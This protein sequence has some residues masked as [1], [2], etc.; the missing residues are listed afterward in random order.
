MHTLL[1]RISVILLPVLIGAGTLRA[2]EGAEGLPILT[3]T[4]TAA[5][6]AKDGQKV[7]VFGET[8]RSGKSGSGMNFV[9]FK[10]AEFYLVTFKSDLAA[11]K[12][13]EPSD[14]YNGKRLAVAGV[15]SIYK[16]KPQIKL[17]SPD[18]VR[19]LA[20]DEAWP[21]APE[22]SASVAP[23]APPVAKSD[24][25]AGAAKAVETP[26]KKPPVDP[27]QYFK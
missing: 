22:A 25:S 19:V 8:E 6:K 1:H 2:Q 26:T 16:D 24:A 18:Q 11:F 12:E 14:I 10:D 21:K 9:N 20:D 17:T 4:D 15:V 5:L 27:K 13:G 23:A 3:A 7:L